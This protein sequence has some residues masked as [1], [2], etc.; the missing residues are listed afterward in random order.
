[1]TQDYLL[2]LNSNRRRVKRSNSLRSDS[3]VDDRDD[4]GWTNLHVGARK[5]DL[6]EVCIHTLL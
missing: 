3:S 2:R 4:R 5:G 1:M 6:K